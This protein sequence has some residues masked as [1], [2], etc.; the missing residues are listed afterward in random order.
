M[1]KKNYNIWFK[2]KR[3]RKTVGENFEFTAQHLFFIHE[4]TTCYRLPTTI[5]D[6]TSAS[7]SDSAHTAHFRG[8]NDFLV[9]SLGVSYISK[10]HPEIEK[11]TGKFQKRSRRQIAIQD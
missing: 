5:E 3:K 6:K 4:Q 8:S 9:F 2:N 7:V 10:R 1:S 11:R